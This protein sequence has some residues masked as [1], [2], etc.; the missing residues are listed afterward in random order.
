MHLGLCEDHSCRGDIYR[1][2]SN[3]PTNATDPTG[4]QSWDNYINEP[5]R[6]PDPGPPPAPGVGPWSLW[7]FVL[8]E[9]NPNARGA[10]ENQVRAVWARTRQV[11]TYYDYYFCGFHVRTGY[12][13]TTE[14]EFY[15]SVCP[16]D[17]AFPDNMLPSCLP[18]GGWPAVQGGR[19]G[20]NN[21]R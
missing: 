2:V 20:G 21:R 17:P 5:R 16:F 4:L 15:T 9:A 8:N 18:P 14:F 3:S 1:F 19:P 13:I 12:E 6:T 7:S 10:G 11:V